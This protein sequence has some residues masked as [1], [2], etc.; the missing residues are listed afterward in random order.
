MQDY[1]LQFKR[2]NI[3]RSRT[4]LYL[5]PV[6]TKTSDEKKLA[7]NYS[8]RKE[9][10]QKDY[11]SQDPDSDPSLSDSSLRN[12]DSSDDINYKHRRRDKNKSIRNA[13]NRT[14]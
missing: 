1:K 3:E 13:R 2:K 12:S 5:T 4:T 7:I 9:E 8:L 14:L 6:G 11:A 10:S